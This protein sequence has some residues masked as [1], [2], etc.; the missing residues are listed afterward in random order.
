MKDRFRLIFLPFFFLVF[1]SAILYSVN[2]GDVTGACACGDT[3]VENYTM[4]YNL[5]CTETGLIIGANDVIL[6]CAGQYIN[7]SIISLGY[8]INATGRNNITIRNCLVL[9]LNSTMNRD[10]AYAIYLSYTNNSRIENVSINTSEDHAYGLYLRYSNNDTIYDTTI[11]VSGDHCDSLFLD[12]AN[13][14]TGENISIYSAGSTT[15]GSCIYSYYSNFSNFSNLILQCPGANSVPLSLSNSYYSNF[16][17]IA[18][19]S[20]NTAAISASSSPYNIFSDGNLTINGGEVTYILYLSSS[21]NQTL[22]NMNFTKQVSSGF[23]ITLGYHQNMTNVKIN[24]L[25]ILWNDSQFTTCPDNE[26]HTLSGTEYSLVGI[27]GCTNVT[28]LNSSLNDMLFFGECTNCTIENTNITTNG[29]S[30]RIAE[31]NFTRIISANISTRSRGTGIYIYNSTNASITN[32]FIKTAYTDGN[33]ITLQNCYNTSINNT[34]VSLFLHYST[35]F[36][37]INSNYTYISSG[38]ANLTF[39]G[40]TVTYPVYLSGSSHSI[41]TDM[42]LTLINTTVAHI[43]FNGYSINNT[44]INTILLGQTSNQIMSRN[45]GS[46][47][48]GKNFLINL[49]NFNRSALTFTGADASNNFTIQWYVRVNVTNH[50][51]DTIGGASVNSTNNQSIFQDFETTQ[52]DGN[53]S[54]FVMNDTLFRGAGGDIVY[55]TTNFT[56]NK[57]GYFTNSTNFTINDSMTLNIKLDLPNAACGETLV[58]SKT[59]NCDLNCTGTALNIDA[60]DITLD[61]AGHTIEYSREAVG[62][63]VHVLGRTGVTIKNCIILQQNDTFNNTVGMNATFFYKTN[64]SK[65]FNLTVKTLANYTPGV[66]ISYS[67]ANEIANSNIITYG[68]SSEG[69]R[70]GYSPNNTVSNITVNST[71]IQGYGVYLYSYSANCTLSNFNITASAHG[72]M[73]A[74]FSNNCTLSNFKMENHGSSYGAYIQASAN[75]SLRDFWINASDAYYG[76]G[77]QQ[78]GAQNNTLFN[79]TIYSGSIGVYLATAGF[80]NLS[81]FYVNASSASTNALSFSSAF[82]NTIQD[83]NISTASARGVYFFRSENNSLRNI[84][85]FTTGETGAKVWFDNLSTN[86]I[87]VNSTFLG[88]PANQTYIGNIADN[89]SGGNFLVNISNFNRSAVSYYSA[90]NR[91]NVTV[92]WYVRVNVTDHSGT[93]IGGASVNCVNNQSAS[94]SMGSTQND[95][96]TSWFIL[97]DTMFIGDGNNIFYTPHNFTASKSGYVT[98]STNFTINS[99]RTLNIRL[100]LPECGQTITE[101]TTLSIDYNCSGTGFKIGANDLIFDCAGHFINF[102]IITAANGIEAVGRNNITIKNCTI[103][104]QNTSMDQ[105]Y[106]NGTFFFRTNNSR[107]E[108]VTIQVTEDYS[109]G[110][111][112]YISQ[113]NSIELVWVNASGAYADAIL[114]NYANFTNLT[115]ITGFKYVSRGNAISFTNSYYNNLTNS[116]ITTFNGADSSYAVVLSSSSHNHVSNVSLNT[117]GIYAK[118]IRLLGGATNNS[119]FNSTIVTYG[120]YEAAGIYLYSSGNHLFDL[121]ISANQTSGILTENYHNNLTNVLIDTIPV[122]WN[123]SIY[124]ICPDNQIL[125]LSH[126]DYSFVGIIGCTNVTITNSTLNE[127]LLLASCAN[128]SVR[129]TTVFSKGRG[130]IISNS[131]NAILDNLNVSTLTNGANGI[132]INTSGNVTIANVNVT[133]YNIYAACIEVDY[134][135][136]TTIYNVNLSSVGPGWSPAIGLLSSKWPFFTNSTAFSSTS[137]GGTILLTSTNFGNFTNLNATFNGCCGAGLRI[138]SSSNNSFDNIRFNSSYSGSYHLRFRYG[139]KNN[140]LSNFVLLGLLN[141]EIH[142]DGSSPYPGDNLLMNFTN[143][144]RSTIS[145]TGADASNNFTIQWYA[146]INVTDMNGY[147][148]GGASANS[149]N[150]QS[151]TQD[152]GTTASDGNTSWF[153]VNDTLFR[154]AGDNI[155]YS[156]HNFTANK[157]GYA[158]NSTNVTVNQSMTI[159]I[160][161]GVGTTTVSCGDLINQTIIM[162]NDINCSGTGLIINNDSVV[163]DCA[164][165]YINYSTVGYGYGINATGFNNITIKNCIIFQHNTS[166]NQ[167]YANALFFNLTNRSFARNISITTYEANARGIY[168]TYSQNN[169]FDNFTMNLNGTAI[170]LD[171]G[172]RWLNF[173]NFTISF[174]GSGYNAIYS[175]EY[176]V[177]VTFDNF[178]ISN[179]NATAIELNRNRK[180]SILNFNLT[181]N[182]EPAITFGDTLAYYFTQNISNF[183]IDGRELKYYTTDG[184][185]LPC[186]PTPI[187]FS[188]IENEVIFVNCSNLVLENST[189]NISLQVYHTNFTRLNNITVNYSGTRSYAFSPCGLDLQSS[190]NGVFSNITINTA[191]YKA[192]ICHRGS[193]QNNTFNSIRILNGLIYTYGATMANWYGLNLS[194]ASTLGLS[195]SILYENIVSEGCPTTGV[196]RFTTTSGVP[197]RNFTMRNANINITCANLNGIDLAGGAGY[198][199]QY[200]HLF[201]NV[202]LYSNSSGTKAIY[203]YFANTSNFS[204]FTINLTSSNNWHFYIVNSSNLTFTNFSLQGNLTQML[205]LKNHSGHI[206]FLNVSNFNRS[207]ITINSSDNQNNFTLQWYVRINVTDYNGNSIN[208]VS[209]NSTNNQSVTQDFGTTQSNGLTNWMAMNDTLFV[210]DGNNVSYALANFTINKTIAG[211]TYTNSTNVTVNETMTINIRLGVPACGQTLTENLTLEYD[212]NCSATGLI[213]GANY[214]VLD[215]AGHAIEF[216]RESEGNGIQAIGRNNVTIKNCRIFQQNDTFNNTAGMNATWF[217]QVLDSTIS[218]LTILTQANYSFGIAFSYSRLNTI[219]NTSITTYGYAAR[220]LLYASH[221]NTL[222]NIT[223]S[224]NGSYAYIYLLSS[225]NNS[226]SN[227]TIIPNSSTYGIA[228]SSGHNNSLSNFMIYNN[229]S[230]VAVNLF[231]SSNNSLANFIIFTNGSSAN[232]VGMGSNSDFNRL[233]NFTIF[234]NGSGA[235]AVYIT[236]SSNNTFSNFTISTNGSSAYGANLRTAFNNSLSNFSIFIN[237]SSTPGIRIYN[238]SDNILFNFIVNTTHANSPKIFFDYNST[239]NSIINITSL[240]QSVNQTYIG[241]SGQFGGDNIL[242]NTTNLNRSAIFYYSADNR[243]NVTFQ[244]YVKVNVSF[245][246]GTPV[247]GASVNATNNQS[248][249]QDFGTTGVDGE[250]SQWFIMNDTIFRG[251]EGDVVYSTTNFSVQYGFMK[252][253]TNFTINDS[254]TI[255]IYLDTPNVYC[256]DTITT[257]LTLN[258]DL[259]CSATAITIGA[260]DLILDCAGHAIEYARI[261][262]GHGIYSNGKINNTVKNCRIFRHNDTFNNTSGMDGINFRRTN[263]SRTINIT[264][265]T[266]GNYSYGISFDN[267]NSNEANFSSITTYGYDSDGFEL[268]NGVRNLSINYANVS[269]NGSEA[270]G[271]SIYNSYPAERNYISHINIFTNG[272]SAYGVYI[273]WASNNTLRNFTINTTGPIGYGV[274]FSFA[275]FN[276]LSD[277][278]IN[279]STGPR[280]WRSDHNIFT[281]FTETISDGI[282]GIYC[283]DSF[284]STFASFSFNSTGS[285]YGTYIRN[286]SNS[287]IMNSVINVTNSSKSHIFLTYNSTWNNIINVTFL[288]ARLNHTYTGSSGQFGGDNFIL[289]ATNMNRSAIIFQSA[290]NRN[291]VTLQWYVKVN[292]S[293][294]NGTP[295]NGA[296]VN[297]T[298]YQSIFQDLGTTGADGETSQWFVM[299]DTMFRGAGGDIVYSTTNFTANY[300]NYLNSSNFTINQSGIITI[301]LSDTRA[302]SVYLEFPENNNITSSISMLFN[303]SAVDD[304]GLANI[305]LFIWNSTNG[306]YYNN[307]QSSLNLQNSS[308]WTLNS[309]PQDTYNWTCNGTDLWGNRGANGTN[310]TFTI[311]TSATVISLNSPNNRFNTSLQTINFNCSATDSGGLSNITI[312]IW[313]SS[314]SLFYNKTTAILNNDNSTNWTLS[315]IPEGRYN[316]TCNASDA[317]GNNGFTVN[318]TFTV[319]YTPPSLI[320][321]VSPQNNLATALQT[322]SFN[323]SGVD[324]FYLSNFTL[325]IWNST[326]E[327]FFNSTRAATGA[328]NYS[329]WTVSSFSEGVYNWTCNVSD[330]VGNGRVNGTNRTFTI[331]MSATTVV[332]NSPEND[333]SISSTTVQFNCSGIDSTGLSNVTLFIWNSTNSLYYMNTTDISNP[334]NESIWNV[335]GFALDVYNWTC[336]ASDIVGNEGTTSNRT[337][338]IAN[339]PTPPSPDEDEKKNMNAQVIANYTNNPFT[340]IAQY[341]GSGLQNALATLTLNSQTISTCYTNS[342]GTCQMNATAAGIYYVKITRAGYYD[343]Q[344]QIELLKYNCTSNDECN[345]DDI[346][347]ENICEKITGEC[348]Y[349]KEHKWI[350]Y[351][352]CADS[353]C[354][355]DS[356]CANNV[357]KKVVG[358]CGYV[359]VH[360]WI[361]YECC[362]SSD[363][364]SSQTCTNNICSGSSTG[365]GNGTCRI[366]GQNCGTCCTGLYCINGT[367]AKESEIKP[368]IKNNTYN[369]TPPIKTNESNKSFIEKIIP[370]KVGIKDACDGIIEAKTDTTTYSICCN[371]YYAL[372]ILSIL[373]SFVYFRKRRDWKNSLLVALIPFFITLI[374][375]PYLAFIG[376]LIIFAYLARMEWHVY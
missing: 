302:P 280:I 13:S 59:L 249:F 168:T 36:N 355:S 310:R 268:V 265:Y 230:G 229:Y 257:N 154:G 245:T 15:S 124:S 92:Q 1:S 254:Q 279:A 76:V 132:R 243:N 55:S 227:F 333:Y 33:G 95:G 258:T 345:E 27:I 222:Y 293:F 164:G 289:N 63:G 34:N 72:L 335:S 163:L 360:K 218:N 298:N 80:N 273:G 162:A 56:V 282:G 344:I 329:N 251:A 215:C 44:F 272:S 281:N 138:Y 308:S 200:D 28:I 24:S 203:V 83:F 100:G 102:S 89:Y 299:N 47:Y 205:Y 331:D 70:L 122:M 325:T 324:N 351:E 148:I 276:N 220:T 292:V 275:S 3:V 223:H 366:E 110:A 206:I 181:T 354:S 318:Y 93:A 315:N 67:R 4:T 332:L 74:S 18:T 287:T 196:I 340:I 180:F 175:G 156:L 191:I 21:P 45:S 19:T 338:T 370:I 169:S 368:P 369:Y 277:F 140:T 179:I 50:S 320:Q 266:L 172:S 91:N 9:Q 116:S 339:A 237:Y 328:S 42:N 16:S 213:I 269:T 343:V 256:G 247:N 253:S 115:R 40:G 101:N 321:L 107:I 314:Y 221:N 316:W 323:C 260:N 322:L 319:D 334:S 143:L 240:G 267:C 231:S 330:N 151:L 219:A 246:N 209:G 307:T 214:L 73:M 26:I 204:F 88:Q 306:L 128:C 43:T 6:D 288:G 208:L 274:G 137:D 356:Y 46:S 242:L 97:N 192:A 197:L 212:L 375:Y 159:N 105:N 199:T 125:N 171:S 190:V 66:S 14:T 291:N 202:T 177:N 17:N 23:W 232:G 53:T 127:T 173:T 142:S 58:A 57:S 167:N 285:S 39:S 350:S 153:I 210:G 108:N 294:T 300:S 228:L 349:A 346:C 373:N 103:L 296:S 372:F 96:N 198:A 135:E 361:Y 185:G 2:C 178:T 64:N 104:Q 201:Q 158:T 241:T 31:S 207:A 82:N 32:S 147:A 238:S 305:T 61:C 358:E 119:I 250:T 150:N 261:S 352:C 337:F 85:I 367:C 295:I 129:N 278:V 312:F 304:V 49:T 376:S 20:S 113:N 133:I 60:D 134:S 224:T 30:I 79:F 51:G 317:S 290:D 144:N 141:D 183:T 118:A 25:P 217:H 184:Y 121:N 111:S 211:V 109:T 283:Q 84:S 327:L 233:H 248:I 234:T 146:R 69:I 106:A 357:C 216:A 139:S 363:C 161:L 98:N 5:N 262:F 174:S 149:T 341:A 62:N 186:P 71:G 160:I 75:N 336:N 81:L 87:I 353:Q 152:F 359:G 41:F 35:A 239:N 48:P 195:N 301:Y 263:S 365:T 286:C 244:W 145:F 371:I 94:V 120:S 284:N 303:C 99:T 68:Y 326:Q 313:N 29:T 22:L 194:S 155:T 374:S 166:M 12:Y 236:F 255:T 193:N 86:N 10:N 271:I 131:S 52:D 77:L 188:E 182:G 78:S 309:I 112:I 7:Y 165:H 270:R 252:N 117:T 225:T 136:N 157:T 311:D 187:S 37:L 114:L 130:I 8:G 54:W 362:K 38:F 65:I 347:K 235:Y 123:D 170:Y 259:N 297:A 126:N 364:G 176:N 11:N 348:G 264:I 189:F 90:D 342:S 226:L